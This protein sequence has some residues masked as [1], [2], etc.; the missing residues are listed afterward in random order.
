MLPSTG[1]TITAAISL[2]RAE[3]SRRQFVVGVAVVASV[4]LDD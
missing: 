4:E 1:S 2:P 3:T